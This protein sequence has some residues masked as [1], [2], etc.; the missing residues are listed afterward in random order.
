MKAIYGV[1]FTADD[2]NNFTLVVYHNII[3]SMRAL[4]QA[5]EDLGIPIE[6]EVSVLCHVRAHVAPHPAVRAVAS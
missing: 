4:V 2:I 6:C 1:G 5:C 3:T